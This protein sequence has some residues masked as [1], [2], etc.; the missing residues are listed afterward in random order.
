VV[1]VAVVAEVTYR[2]H[3]YP[4]HKKRKVEEIAKLLRKYRYVILVNIKGITANVLHETRAM[5]RERGST[6]KVI[7]NTLTKLAI[8]KVKEE[9][10]GIEVLEEYLTGQNAIIFTNENPFEIAIF[11]AKNK[12]AREARPGDVATKEVI[13]PKGNTGMAPGPVISLF[14]KVGVPTTIREGSIFVTKDTVVLREGDVISQDLADLLNKL[15]IKPVE[16]SIEPK[17][18]YLDGKV[19]EGKD[20][21]IDLEEFKN[22]LVQAHMEALNLAVNAAIPTPEVLSNII[23]KAHMEALALAASAGI[24][25][26]ET[27]PIVISRAYAAALNL[28]EKMKKVKPEL[29]G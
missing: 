23:A 21:K 6:L 26:P 13:I 19:I 15:G 9:K 2:R 20:I 22:S 27:A 10:A 29:A 28:Y 7:K 18:A 1:R 8:E 25:T 14:N 11:L 3:K 24:L 5:L 16:V 12:I 4:E 17:V